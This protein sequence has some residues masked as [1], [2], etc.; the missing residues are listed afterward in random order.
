M[1]KFLIEVPHSEDAYE[2]A[3]AVKV[4]LGSGS[5]FLMNADWGCCDGEHK[6]WIILDA[7]DKEQARWVVPPSFR[8][9]AKITTLTKFTL[10]E[11]DE[12]MAQHQH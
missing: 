8:P 9:D 5:H 1:P 10:E 12:I 3:M 2:C 4:F 11:M 6:A 7:E